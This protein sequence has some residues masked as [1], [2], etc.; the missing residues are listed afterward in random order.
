MTIARNLALVGSPG[1]A[2]TIRGSIAISG[3]VTVGLTDLVVTGCADARVTATGGASVTGSGLVV[4]TSAFP[5]CPFL[6]ADG[7]ESADMSAWSSSLP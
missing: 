2:S 1:G 6:F 7:F 5:A 3:A 4:T